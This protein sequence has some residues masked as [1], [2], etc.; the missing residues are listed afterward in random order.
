MKIKTRN[1]LAVILSVLCAV[2]LAVGVSFVLPKNEVKTAHAAGGELIKANGAVDLDEA[3]ALAQA[4]GYTDFGAMY[5]ALE[6]GASISGSGFHDYVVTV[7]GKNWYAV[8]ASGTELTLLYVGEAYSS[9]WSDGTYSHDNLTINSNVYEYSYIRSC[10]NAGATQYLG[11]FPNYKTYNGDQKAPNAAVAP[12]TH[13]EFVDFLPGGRFSKY[14]IAGPL[15]DS[16]WLPGTGELGTWGA[17][18]TQLSSSK[19]MW[20]RDPHATTRG[21]ALS[22]GSDGSIRVAGDNVFTIESIRPAIIVDISQFCIEEPTDVTVTYNGNPQTLANVA[23]EDKEWYD[24]AKMTLDYVDAPMTDKGTY[25]VKAT[26]TQDL[27]DQEMKFL[28][29]PDT[30]K[31][32]TDYIRYFE[33]KIDPKPLNATLTETD[34]N[35][36]LT[37][38]QSGL[39]GS[40]SMPTTAIQYTS[41]DGNG[42]NSTTAPAQKGS[43]KAEA[44]ITDTNSN[45]SLNCTPASVTYTINAIKVD[46][47]AL[48]PTA[49]PEYDGTSQT[50]TLSNYTHDGKGVNIFSVSGKTAS[51]ASVATAP[52]FD[53]ANGTVTFKDAGTYTVTF[54]LEDTVNCVWKSDS[55]TGQKNITF[56]VKPKQLTV[57]VTNNNGGLWNWGIGTA[58]D[59]T[60]TV[61]DIIS[62]DNVKLTTSYTASTGVSVSSTGTAN[63]GATSVGDTISLPANLVQDTYTL[64]AQIDNE[65]YSISDGLIAASMPLSFTIG[66]AVFD[67]DAFTWTYSENGTGSTAIADGDNFL[68][69]KLDAAGKPYEYKL[70]I[71]LGSFVSVFRTLTDSDYTNHKQTDADT[72]TTTVRLTIKDSDYSFDTTKIY[73]NAT[74]ISTTVAD[75]V[76]HWTI[77][78][79]D[80][81]DLDTLPWVYRD[82]T[83]GSWVDYNPAK[84][85]EYSGKTITVKLKG[86]VDGT[87][88]GLKPAYGAHDAE[89]EISP[90]VLNVSFSVT[91]TKNFNVPAGITFNWEITKKQINVQWEPDVALT[92]SGT[93]YPEW[94]GN[95]YYATQLRYDKP[96]FADKVEYIYSCTLPDGSTYSGRG[97]EALAYITEQALAA[98]QKIAVEVEVELKSDPT[99][100]KSYELNDTTGGGYKTTFMVG[101]NKIV[102]KVELTTSGEYSEF[103]YNLTVTGEDMDSGKYTVTVYKGTNISDPDDPANT[104]IDNFDPKTAD[105]GEYFV[106]VALTGDW[107]NEYRL[108][109]RIKTFEILPKSVDL[110]V[111]GNIV[112]SGKDINLVD[113]MTGFD[114]NLMEFV[115]GGDFEGL[116]NV[117]ENGYVAQ[118]KLKDSNYRWKYD[119]SKS[120][121]KFGLCD[122]EINKFDDTTAVY[123]WNIAP[124]VVD[125]T[126]MW[127]KGKNGATLNLPKNVKDLI[128]GG[129]L[130]VG[131]RYYDTEGNFIETPEI[132]GNNQFKVEAVFGGDDAVR[133]VQFKTGD[134]TLGNTSPAINY[135]VPQSGIAAFGGKVLSFL[136]NN[137]WWLLIALAVLIFLIILIVVIAKRRKNKEE[138]EEK[139]RQKEEEKERREEEKRRREEEREAERERQKHELELAKAKQE[140]EL[141]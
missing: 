73:T 63:G 101:D 81:T 90:Y 111:I 29:T 28:G 14:I 48:P 141:A 22:L 51:N 5:Q 27:I 87:L 18:T 8:Y 59:A 15:G 65:N 119:D 120:T 55:S 26:L 12:N 88:R 133:N 134:T 25:K 92:Y 107:D 23:A 31:G 58:V 84:P 46:L 71:N 124:L 130:E 33:F 1:L 10:L 80:F 139:K 125:T 61:S 135:T 34:G 70:S 98:S 104:K 79:G 19:W 123:K 77:Q 47:P 56:T 110:P 37:V 99:I 106:V 103:N 64:S 76:I 89:K 137:W 42:Y 100:Q 126:N 86:D 118:L 78:K 129:T 3:K 11:G 72:Y 140:A 4:A 40:D 96:E 60:V 36:T 102:A 54:T 53:T 132:K 13:T 68:K 21:H 7:G 41:T 136:K 50:I 17:T 114:A 32:E 66:A 69:Y 39:C 95:E 109:G 6:S 20:L 74:I 108:S 117:S 67:P 16:V 97:V 35:V 43:F 121:A 24:S 82:G 91:D 94:N 93:K 75:V 105:A 138:R 113:Y 115:A 62:G 44:V 128:A 116:R 57:A 83:S 9:T 127:S 30:S 112:F 122:Y 38:D 131:Y 85:P 49:V 45:Y 52:T 2:L